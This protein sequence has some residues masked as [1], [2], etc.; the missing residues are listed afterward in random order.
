MPATFTAATH[1]ATDDAPYQ[2]AIAYLCQLLERGAPELNDFADLF[3][4]KREYNKAGELIDDALSSVR[5]NEV[6]S[7][8]FSELQ[9]IHTSYSTKQTDW[10]QALG[11]LVEGAFYVLVMNKYKSTSGVRFERE[12]SVRVQNTSGGA[13]TD[14]KDIDVIAWSDRSESGEFLEVKKAIESYRSNPRFSEKLKAMV[15]FRTQLQAITEKVSFVAVASLFDDELITTQ[16][17]KTILQIFDETTPLD[18][19]ILVR[20][21]VLTW[22]S[23]SYIE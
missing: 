20:S 17:L 7:A 1:P 18:I 2:R 23:Q 10:T 3:N 5:N 16:I 13:H 15:T 19:D 22:I 8:F 11:A 9:Q 12:N 21:K 14:G 4:P 6:A